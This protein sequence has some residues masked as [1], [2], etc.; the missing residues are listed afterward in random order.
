M[1]L[2]AVDGSDASRGAEDIL[3][4]YLGSD[5]PELLVLNVIEQEP[6]PMA[7]PESKAD[8]QTDLIERAESLVAGAKTRLQKKGFN[9]ETSVEHGHPGTMICRRADERDV[10]GIFMGRRGRGAAGELLMGSVS[11]HVIHHAPCPVTL[12]SAD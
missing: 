6:N 12:V 11:Q 5:S 7:G 2:L 4:Q 10:E 1:Y 9:V 3:V 8:M